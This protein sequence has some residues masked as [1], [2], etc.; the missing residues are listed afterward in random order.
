MYQA[1]ENFEGLS[2]SGSVEEKTTALITLLEAVDPLSAC[3]VVR[4]ILQK[5]RLGFS[6]M[7]LIDAFSWML[8]VINRFEPELNMHIT[9]V[10][11]L[12]I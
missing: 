11:I 8:W 1:L 3:F 2:G 6:E 5:L 9:S 4:V 12:A 7:T 10:P